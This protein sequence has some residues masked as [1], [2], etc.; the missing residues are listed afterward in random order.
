MA[1]AVHPNGDVLAGGHFATRG[2]AWPSPVLRAS[3]DVLSGRRSTAVGGRVCR[4]Q[5]ARTSCSPGPRRGSGPASS[6][7]ATGLSSGGLAVAVL[8]LAA[9]STPLAAV[10]PQ[11]LPGCSLLV[12]P[13][14]LTA[15]VPV[16]GSAEVAFAIPAAPSL[17]A[18]TFRQQ[19]VGLDV[20][21]SGAILAF[22][23]TNALLAVIGSY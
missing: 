12:S 14:V 22:T 10:V 17:A 5:A 8:G 7:Q 9:Q 6:R 15:L 3:R 11:G 2:G 20:A 21:A 23:S 4:S 1:L 16:A 13:D 18:Q 19:V